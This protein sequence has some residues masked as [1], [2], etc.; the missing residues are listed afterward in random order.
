MAWLNRTVHVG[1]GT[2]RT[3]WSTVSSAAGLLCHEPAVTV[4][5]RVGF[6]FIA[7]CG[8]SEGPRAACLLGL[9]PREVKSTGSFGRLS[10]LPRTGR[11]DRLGLLGS[12]GGKWGG[13]PAAN[14]AGAPP[15]RPVLTPLPSLPPRAGSV[16][17]GMR[18]GL[19]WLGLLFQGSRRPCLPC[20]VW[21]TPAC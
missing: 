20:G 7:S 13:H 15:A 18:R 16:G 21:G 17:P 2:A 14:P 10:H 3:A 8:E 6:S 1:A 5:W 4:G 12:I 11:T 19:P 9:C